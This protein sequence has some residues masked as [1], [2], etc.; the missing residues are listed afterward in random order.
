M[1]TDSTTWESPASSGTPA[2]A[3]VVDTDSLRRGGFAGADFGAD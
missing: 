3:L 1:A 2:P